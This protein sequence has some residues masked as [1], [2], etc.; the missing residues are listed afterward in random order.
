MINK[1][2]TSVLRYSNEC[3]CKWCEWRDKCSEIIKH[4][5]LKVTIRTI[6]IIRTT[7]QMCIAA[8]KRF[9]NSNT[10]PIEGNKNCSWVKR[11]NKTEIC[12]WIIIIRSSSSNKVQLRIYK[13]IILCFLIHMAIY[14]LVKHLKCNEILKP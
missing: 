6:I 8:I 2:L 12:N 11:R 5:R 3:R 10:S 4:K 9:K 14:T 7:I 1:F 13:I